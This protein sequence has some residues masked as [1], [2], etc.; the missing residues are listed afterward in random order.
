MV[1]AGTGT[2]EQGFGAIRYG[3]MIG[4][5]THYRIY[6]KYFNRDSAVH[7]SGE[8]AADSWDVFRTGF[9]M[10][11]T[12]SDKDRLTLQGDVYTGQTG[13]TVITKSFNPT[14]PATFDQENDI[15]GANLLGRWKHSISDTSNIALQVY[16]DYTDRN[17]A[18][19]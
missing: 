15:A 13:E 16:Y 6:A 5:K 8:D 17:S 3:G 14:D 4:Q 1:I 7:V 19:T 12:R 2:E 11:Y 9:R 18:S 10:D